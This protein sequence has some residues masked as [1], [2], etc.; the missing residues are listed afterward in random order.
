MKL[1]L[2]ALSALLLVPNFINVHPGK[3]PEHFKKDKFDPKLAYIN[4]IEKL[5]SVSDSIARSKNIPETSFGYALTVSHLLVNRFYHGYS[6]YPVNE[7]W[8]AATAEHLFGYGLASIVKP[9]DILKYNFGACSQQAIVFTEVMKVKKIPFRSVSFPHHYATELKYNNN[10]YFF[11][12]NLEPDITDSGRLETAWH[13]NIENL[14]QYYNKSNHNID[15]FF[16]FDKAKF[17]DVNAKPAANISMFHT[18]TNY[19]SKTLWL[20]PLFFVFYRRKVKS[21]RTKYFTPL[22]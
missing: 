11:D 17:G 13:H 4:S 6:R 1:L 7:N 12:T 8:I 9:D 15:W 18:T 19:L 20:F 5:I 2:I 21:N 10:W 14:K 3:I 16:G 22:D